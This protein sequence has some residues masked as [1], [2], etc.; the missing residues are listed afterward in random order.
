MGLVVVLW[1]FDGGGSGGGGNIVRG[2]KRVNINSICFCWGFTVGFVGCWWW[3]W[4]LV[5]EE[6]GR[7]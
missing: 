1:V 3:W 4:R 2:R 5:E 6:E 7:E